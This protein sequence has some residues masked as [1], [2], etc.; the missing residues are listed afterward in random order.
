MVWLRRDDVWMVDVDESGGHN[1]IFL[2]GNLPHSA[3][4]D[5]QGQVAV[6]KNGPTVTDI[7][8][9]HF[10]QRRRFRRIDKVSAQHT[11]GHTHPSGQCRVARYSAQASSELKR[12]ST[13]SKV[14]G[15]SPSMTP[16]TTDWS[17]RVK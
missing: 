15:K 10:S 16:K 6:L 3:E 5:R 17:W 11:G 9:R 1:A 8:Y 14:L 12:H 4:A 2:T 7:S 13:C